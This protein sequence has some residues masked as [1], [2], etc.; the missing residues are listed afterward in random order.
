MKNAIQQLG[1]YR[2]TYIM[3]ATVI[4]AGLAQ[5]Y[6]DNQLVQLAIGIAGIFGVFIVPNRV[7]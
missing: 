1:R 4:L 2:K 6:G 7:K 5:V 3:I